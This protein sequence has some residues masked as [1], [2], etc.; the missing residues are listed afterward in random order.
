MAFIKLAI[1]K[2]LTEDHGD[3]ITHEI[4][5]PIGW[6]QILDFKYLREPFCVRFTNQ[7]RDSGR[8][9][10]LEAALAYAQSEFEKAINA[11]FLPSKRQL[12]KIDHL[13][14]DNHQVYFSSPMSSFRADYTVDVYKDV[15][16]NGE[17]ETLITSIDVTV[18]NQCH[19]FVDTD[20]T[21]DGDIVLDAVLTDDMCREVAN[22]VSDMLERRNGSC[23]C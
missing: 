7:S 18:R 10:T 14:L 13:D 17:I 3:F 19:V 15:A 22:L 23:G 20:G 1:D 16:V 11:C 12:L 21:K 9:E 6:I 2:E 5:T 4:R 8:F